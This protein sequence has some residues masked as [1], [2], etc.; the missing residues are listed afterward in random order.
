MNEINLSFKNRFKACCLH[1][2]LSLNFNVF[3]DTDEE[4]KETFHLFDKDNGGYV[5]SIDIIRVMK[6]LG[7]EFNE[8][9]IKQFVT[10]GGS[11]PGKS[12]TC[13]KIYIGL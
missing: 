12:Y 4:M 8:Q 11:G 2:K 1:G 13:S 9:E 5:T 3:N 10:V 7:Q 6:A